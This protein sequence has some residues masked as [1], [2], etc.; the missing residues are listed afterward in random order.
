MRH[1]LYLL[2]LL[3]ISATLG[4]QVRV[5]DTT[6]G[7]FSSWRNILNANKDI[8]FIGAGPW[9]VNGKGETPPLF[10]A[11]IRQPF[12]LMRGRDNQIPF[13]RALS[14]NFNLGLNLRMYQG[15][16]NPSY[17]V[18]PIN[19]VAPGF[20]VDYLLNQLVRGIHKIAL[21]DSSV[22]RNYFTFQLLVSHYSNGQSGSFYTADSTNTNKIDGNFSTNFV[23]PQVTW[24]R[25]L[26]NDA[27]TSAAVSWTHDFGIGN[28]LGIEEGLRNS[29]GFNK[30]HLTLQY[31]TQNVR[32]GSYRYQESR[33]EKKEGDTSK[34]IVRMVTIQRFKRYVSWMARVEFGYI[35]DN[36]DDYPTFKN[37][38]ENKRRLSTKCTLVY[39]PANARTLGLFAMLYA[40]R[41]YY[42]IRYTDQLLNIKF[43]FLFDLDRHIPPNTPYIPVR[44]TRA[45]LRT[46]L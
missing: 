46:P 21:E 9:K 30:L 8:N 12:L 7:V 22:I 40:G 38:S 36:V 43:G 39:Y 44:R 19:F 13:K 35:L 32:F 26:P 25:Y 34:K 4:A 28:A 5:P 31:K 16:E 15:D 23:R 42:N 11:Q 29:Y 1:T 14:L 6:V 3:S 24:S 41:D 20:S 27:L 45:G 33:Y 2:T 18:R 37:R 10:E 17:P